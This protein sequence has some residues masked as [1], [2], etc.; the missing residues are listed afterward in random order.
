V[1]FRTLAN[2]RRGHTFSA[3]ISI[4]WILKTQ[5]HAEMVIQ[6]SHKIAY[7]NLFLKVGYYILY[8]YSI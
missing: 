1:V 5:T 2:T 3:D 6:F 7:I 4:E 8:Y